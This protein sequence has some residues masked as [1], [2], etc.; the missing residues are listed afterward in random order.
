M[1]KGLESD[2]IIL[3]L[4]KTKKVIPSNWDIADKYVGTTRA[5]SFLIIYEFPDPE[6]DFL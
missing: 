1:Y 3:F 6:I 5:R 4:E 2:V